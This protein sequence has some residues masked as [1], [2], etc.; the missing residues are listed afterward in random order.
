MLR[1]LISSLTEIVELKNVK[2]RELHVGLH[3]IGKQPDYPYESIEQM[4]KICSHASKMALSLELSH[5]VRTK[6]ENF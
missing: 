3:Y 2:E 4:E 1:S 5:F 6:G